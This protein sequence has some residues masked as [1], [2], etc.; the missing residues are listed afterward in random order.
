M[1]LISER[2]DVNPRV[3]PSI[4]DL[5]LCTALIMVLYVVTQFA[6]SFEATALTLEIR[7]RQKQLRTEIL[8]AVSAEQAKGLT[9]TEDGNL[10]RIAFADQVLFDSG[11]AV[12]KRTGRAV[13][14]IVGKV[15]EE[16]SGVFEKVQVE[17]HTDDLPL[18]TRE[19]FDSNWELSS[20]RS[21]SVV[22][23][24]QDRCKLAPH[25]L[26]A[27]GYS[28]YHP[29]DPRK[30]DGARAK[31]RRVELV[32]VYSPQTIRVEALGDGRPGA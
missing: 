24:L 5:A 26:S 18:R 27:T 9:I 16:R 20:A 2:E 7:T 1:K 8:S 11:K 10:Q 12:L 13:L 14:G 17:G 22:R 25:L 31:N 28:E 3:W 15:L 30:T 23:F 21:T 6:I 32:V 29:V 19:L 4:A